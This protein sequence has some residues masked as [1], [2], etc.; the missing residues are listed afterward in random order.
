MEDGHDRTLDNDGKQF[1][2]R[3]TTNF[4]DYLGITNIGHNVFGDQDH[5]PHHQ[6]AGRE[7]LDPS[8]EEDD[9]EF[10]TEDDD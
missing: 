1:V 9:G 5:L 4:F 10:S 3:M 7:V 6:F 2:E 8:T